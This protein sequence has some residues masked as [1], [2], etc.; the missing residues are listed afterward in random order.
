[1]RLCRVRLGRGTEP[2]PQHA[3]RTKRVRATMRIGRGRLAGDIR[4]SSAARRE[5]HIRPRT[6]THDRTRLHTRA[7]MQGGVPLSVQFHLGSG[8]SAPQPCPL[9]PLC[10]FN[11]ST[12]AVMAGRHTLT[13]S[14]RHRVQ[15]PFNVHSGARTP[16]LYKQLRPPRHRPPYF[17]AVEV[18]S[19]S[20]IP[21]ADTIHSYTIAVARGSGGGRD[22]A[23]SVK[24]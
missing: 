21:Y 2:A 24:V 11:H 15:S 18:L 4:D 16:H 14:M 13:H 8:P 7:G 5:T 12:D 10:V 9:R 17:S 20:R 23:I 1:M 3:A 19:H 22:E 6:T